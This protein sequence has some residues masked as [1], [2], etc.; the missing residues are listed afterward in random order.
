[1]RPKPGTMT[2]WRN[3]RAPRQS[4]WRNLPLVPCR[5]ERR[6]VEGTFDHRPGRRVCRT[7][8]ERL[9]DWAE[10]R[11]PRSPDACKVATRRRLRATSEDIRGR[12]DTTDSVGGGANSLPSRRNSA[13]RS[14]DATTLLRLG[15]HSDP[16]YHVV[17]TRRSVEGARWAMGCPAATAQRRTNDE[18]DRTSSITAGIVDDFARFDRA[19]VWRHCALDATRKTPAAV[20]V[21]H[22]GAVG[23]TPINPFAMRRAIR[24]PSRGRTPTVFTLPTLTNTTFRRTT[25]RNARQAVCRPLIVDRPPSLSHPRQRSRQVARAVREA[26]HHGAE[27]R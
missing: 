4:N 18:P 23:R 9:G 19:D 5:A 14:R 27:E 8:S 13:A 11:L 25:Q 7:R 20:T 22:D 10:R 15:V 3:V 21:C 16:A 17:H 1:V 12:Y 24:P 26:I 6:Q 2:S